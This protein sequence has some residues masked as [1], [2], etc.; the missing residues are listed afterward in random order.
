[1]LLQAYGLSDA[2]TSS[3]I[4]IFAAHDKNLLESTMLQNMDFTQLVE[5]SKQGRQELQHLFEEDKQNI[6]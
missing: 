6:D 2:E 4:D 1:M 5:L 3:L